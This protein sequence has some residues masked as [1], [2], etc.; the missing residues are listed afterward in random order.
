MDKEELNVMLQ[1]GETHKIEF[2]ESLEDIAKELV[3]FANSSGGRIL[4]GVKDDGTIKGIKLTK[5][6]KSQ[7]QDIANNCEPKIE[8]SMESLENVL[9]IS[10][11]EGET[12]ARRYN[13]R[14]SSAIKMHQRRQKGANGTYHD[15]EF[16]RCDIFHKSSVTL[17]HIGQGGEK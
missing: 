17:C 10:V 14:Q 4:L 13:L 1:E 11:A 9:V 5:A 6:L 3:A 12:T 8:I 2:K 15:Y 7:I 16:N